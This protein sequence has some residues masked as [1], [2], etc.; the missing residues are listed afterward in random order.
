MEGAEETRD[1]GAQPAK[2]VKKEKKKKNI[3]GCC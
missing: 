2:M 3:T 1:G